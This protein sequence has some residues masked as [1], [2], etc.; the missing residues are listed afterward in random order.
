MLLVDDLHGVRGELA[1]S[2]ELGGVRKRGEWSGC[3]AE[4]RVC[5][6]T[7]I[8]GNIMSRATKLRC[9]R[10]EALKGVA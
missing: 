9:W 4:K 2:L 8:Q 6:I 1:C 7:G 10:S 5:L 3:E